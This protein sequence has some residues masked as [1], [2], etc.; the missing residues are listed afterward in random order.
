MEDDALTAVN[1]PVTHPKEIFDKKTIGEVPSLQLDDYYRPFE[2]KRGG[3]WRLL[4]GS[5]IFRFTYSLR[6]P[7][8]DREEQRNMNAVQ[9]GEAVIKRLALEVS[10]DGAVPLV[11]YLPYKDEIISKKNLA[12]SARM[13]QNSGIQYFDPTSCLMT[14]DVSNA[15]MKENHYSP[16]ASAQIAGCLSPLVR[17]MFNSAGTVQSRA[18]VATRQVGHK[19][20][21]TSAP[22]AMHH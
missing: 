12:L 6:P 1:E 3:I 15:Y 5:Y 9:L 13:L 17:K 16:E 7:S 20:Q 21:R 18:K 22:T 14:M 10:R 19:S 2:W 4:E 8:D 11:V